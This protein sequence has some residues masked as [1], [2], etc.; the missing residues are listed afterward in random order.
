MFKTFP[1]LR[2]FIIKLVFL[3]QCYTPTV[4]TLKSINFEGGGFVLED[5]RCITLPDPISPHI[6][7]AGVH[8]APH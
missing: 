3:S 5:G 7:V 4:T 1:T 8:L 6:V 2:L